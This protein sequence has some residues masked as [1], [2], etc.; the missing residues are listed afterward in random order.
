MIAA[1][2]TEGYGVGGSI[3]RVVLCGYVSRLRPKRIY[4][5]LSGGPVLRAHITG[6]AG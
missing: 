5:Y 3:S 4:A 6:G 1:I 2:V